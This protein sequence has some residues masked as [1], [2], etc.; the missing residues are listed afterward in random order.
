MKKRLLAVFAHPDD[1]SFGPGGTLAKY[2]ALEVEVFL[3][4]ATRGEAGQWSEVKVGGKTLS[5]IRARE[6]RQ[7]VKI[8][9]VKQVAF[10]N[11]R[12]GQIANQDVCKLTQKILLKIKK[13][14]PQV[15]LT[16]D[17]TGI[18]LH[19]DHIAVAVATTRAFLESKIPQKL[20]YHVLPQSF[21]QKFASH[22]PGF[23]DEKITTKIRTSSMWGKKV[24]AMKCHLTQKKDWERILARWRQG[25][26]QEFFYL[27]QNRIKNLKIPEDD[28]FAGVGKGVKK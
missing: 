10:L 23:P 20:Y 8:L 12:D 5:E 25:K 21:A 14:K 6:E 2:A 16:F 22:F 7:A 18:S 1:E 19:L 15:I 13:I 28:L 17:L 3:V 26:K 11:F 24:L 4:T 27:A 9:G